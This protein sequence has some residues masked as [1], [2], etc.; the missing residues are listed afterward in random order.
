MLTNVWYYLLRTPTYYARLHEE[1]D[2]NFPAGEEPFD[3][4]TLAGMPF[5]NAC[6]YALYFHHRTAGNDF[7]F[8]FDS[9]E[10]LRLQPAVP[11]GSQRVVSTGGS[12]VG[13]Q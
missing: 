10:S 2:A 9:N 12:L 1:V 7:N 6:M 13:P 4:E 5:L 11:G 3:Q 8:F